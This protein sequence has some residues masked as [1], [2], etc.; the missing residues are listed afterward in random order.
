MTTNSSPN[1]LDDLV[2][3]R[4]GLY[5]CFSRWGD[6]LFELTDA[7][8]CSPGPIASVPSLS[9]EPEFSRS[10]GSLYKALDKGRID[11]ERL[12]R[13]LVAKRPTDWPLVFAVDA[14]TWARSDAETSPERG[15]Y[16]SP[17]KHS[18]GQPIVAGWAYQWVSQLS[19]ANDSWS[20][21]LDA[22]PPPGPTPGEA[23]GGTA[24]RLRCRLRRNRARPRSQR[25]ASRGVLSH[26]RRP[27]VL[28]RPPSA[29][30]PTT[31]NRGT[32]PT[33]RET[34]Q[35]LRPDEFVVPRR[36]VSR[37]RLALRHGEG[38]CLARAA[39]EAVRARALVGARDAADCARK[40][41][42]R[43]RRAPTQADR[44][45]EKDTVA[46]VVGQRGAGPRALRSRLLAPL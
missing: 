3:L 35:V 38:L 1:R 36:I 23:R 22:M 5:S 30:E 44:G 25:R 41:H 12:R 15:F 19:W 20:A 4:R 13:L 9:L 39:P 45:R 28:H 14:S 11:E 40:R 17:S 42:P 46:V 2:G 33:P 24:V 31:G 43:R 8:L 32:S 10:H 27:G 6:A 18:A 37:C 26:P 29:G 7:M 16:H 21:P 34:L